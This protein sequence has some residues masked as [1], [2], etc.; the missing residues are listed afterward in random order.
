M[1]ITSQLQPPL[2]QKQQQQQQ[3]NPLPVINAPPTVT[4]DICTV[5]SQSGIASFDDTALLEI[6]RKILAYLPKN[7]LASIFKLILEFE[8]FQNKNSIATFLPVS[9]T[10][11]SIFLSDGINLT[12]KN[13]DGRK[14]VTAKA[15]YQSKPLEPRINRPG[16]ALDLQDIANKQTITQNTPVKLKSNN[17]NNNNTN[18]NTSSIIQH[19]T[20]LAV[21]TLHST[22]PSNTLTQPIPN[23]NQAALLQALRES[24]IQFDI[25]ASPIVANNQIPL[26]G[27]LSAG[28]IQNNLPTQSLAQSSNNLT[29]ATKINTD[30]AGI[31]SNSNLVQQT[32][33]NSFAP[34]QP[35]PL[36][37]QQTTPIKIPTE[38][39][40]NNNPETPIRPKTEVLKEKKKK[41]KTVESAKAKKAESLPKTSLTIQSGCLGALSKNNTNLDKESTTE[42]KPEPKVINK[43]E[44]TN[45]TNNA[46]TTENPS[47]STESLK[48]NLIIKLDLIFYIIF[49]LHVPSLNQQP[50]SF[51]LNA[52]KRF[53]QAGV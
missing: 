2:P 20:P 18:I 1:T 26:T 45:N 48:M 41:E 32:P 33:L 44:Q 35:A 3:L 42:N 23:L 7:F 11:E 36:N 38:T 50:H 5:L 37:I 9:Q 52:I 53:L 15:E 19:S 21:T 49:E 24:P 29:T 51:V 47:E 25:R 22:L 28:I 27:R 43:Q 6:A 39:K 12:R 34:I 16:S 17:N 40:N 8:S 10:H 13:V 4:V 31:L 14:S 46:E 30:A